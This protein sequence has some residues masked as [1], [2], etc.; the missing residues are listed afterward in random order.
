[1]WTNIYS[2]Q[3]GN[4]HQTKVRISP[5]S[6]LVNQWVLGFL[7]GV[8]VRVRTAGAKV[9]LLT[10][11]PPQH[12]WWLIKARDLELT[13]GTLGSACVGA[14]HAVIIHEFLCA[15]ALLCLENVASL[16]SSTTS[17]SYNHSTPPFFMIPEPGGGGVW[18]GC[19]ILDWALWGS[20]FPSAVALELGRY[21]FPR[22]AALCLPFQLPPFWST[23]VV[24]HWFSW[25]HVSPV[26]CFCCIRN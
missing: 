14:V 26:F 15:A 13:V 19:P 3:L 5:K 18:H 1:M 11:S 9:Q 23:S 22:P 4:Q 21:C 7:T 25:G 6:N 10:A 2:P 20:I 16:Q 8:W 24:K 17:S 12:R